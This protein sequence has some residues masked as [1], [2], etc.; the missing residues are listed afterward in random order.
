MGSLE[1]TACG[2]RSVRPAQEAPDRIRGKTALLQKA[3]ASAIFGVIDGRFGTETPI[4]GVG[5]TDWPFVPHR[6]QRALDQVILKPFLAQFATNAQWTE[7]LA[8]P[9]GHVV[10]RQTRLIDGA[11]GRQTIK[12]RDDVRLGKPARDKLTRQ[13]APRMLADRE[14]FQGQASDCRR[15][16]RLARRLGLSLLG[17]LNAQTVTPRRAPRVALAQAPVRSPPLATAYRGS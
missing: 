4:A 2:V 15:R 5:Q 8:H 9:L 17:G 6:F 10:L 1:W 13:F 12:H 3:G 14:Q 7:A 16:V 11:F